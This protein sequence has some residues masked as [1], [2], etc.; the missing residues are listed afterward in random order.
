MLLRRLV[1]AALLAAVFAVAPVT[2]ATAQTPVNAPV[3]VSATTSYAAVG[4]AVLPDG[5][6]VQVS[7][8]H[9]RFG[10]SAWQG[11]LVVGYP[12]TCSYESGPCSPYPPRGSVQLTGDQVHFDRSLAVASVHDVPVTL[13]SR[14]LGPD[15]GYLDHATTVVVSVTFTGTGPVTRSVDHGTVCGSG[16]PCLFSG[17][18]S[19]VRQA[20][21]SLTVDGVTGTSTG[22]M[23][24]DFGVDVSNRAPVAE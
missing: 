18:V 4:E 6:R 10:S 12:L 20:D 5:Q 13:E 23:Y 22:T 17:R 1:P 15:G 11:D 16:D 7:L 24:A 14:E 8:Y 9:Y 19:G 3:D 2:A 21:V